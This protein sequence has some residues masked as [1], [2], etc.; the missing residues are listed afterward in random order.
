[1][2]GNRRPGKIDPLMADPNQDP[3]EEWRIWFPIDSKVSDNEIAELEIQIGHKLPTD[4]II[5]L[6]YKHFYELNISEASF[7]KHPVNTW[8]RELVRMIHEG[9]PKEY[10][11][12]RGLI[13]F[14]DWS[15]WGYLCFYTNHPRLDNNFTIII[16]DH[17]IPHDNQ[18]FSADFKSMMLKL[19]KEDKESWCL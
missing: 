16:W 11:I 18:Y 6:K 7:C 15:D 1:M 4:Y 14:A 3:N 2:K 12:D 10:L 9:Y 8:Y 5:F 17:Y 13:P 19:D